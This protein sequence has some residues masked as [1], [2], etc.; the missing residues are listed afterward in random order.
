MDKEKIKQIICEVLIF[1]CWLIGLLLFVGCNFDYQS[2]GT[3]GR[4]AIFLYPVYVLIRFVIWA[5]RT[6]RKK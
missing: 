5:V 3:R 6:S 2:I 1:L 4:F